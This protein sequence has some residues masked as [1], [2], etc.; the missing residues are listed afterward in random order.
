MVKILKGD[1]RGVLQTF[2]HGE[3]G[4]FGVEILIDIGLGEI[5]RIAICGFL[6]IGINRTIL[7]FVGKIDNSWRTFR[8]QFSGDIDPAV[9]PHLCK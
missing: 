3:C 9:Q 4:C 1:T 6:S 2:H 5:E 8:I 7:I